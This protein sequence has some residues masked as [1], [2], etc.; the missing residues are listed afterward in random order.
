MSKETSKK[1][2]DLFVRLIRNDMTRFEEEKQVIFYGG[3]PLSNFETLEYAATIINDYIKKGLLP[4]KTTMNMVTNGTLLTDEIANRI[5]ELNITFSI[6]LD[7]ATEK[8]NS[9]RKFHNGE[10][11]FN[12]IINGIEIAKRNNCNFGLSMTL[13]EDALKE[14]DKIYDL[15]DKYN[16]NSIGFNILL[17]DKNYSVPDSYFIEASSFLVEAYKVFRQK[18]IYE[19]RMMRKVDAFVNHRLYLQDCA[20]QGGNQIIIAPNGEIGLCHGY[21]STRETFVDKVGNDS[22]DPTK[23]EVFIEWNK[24]SPVNMNQCLFCPALGFCGGGCPLNA[25]A[26]GE[27]I[28]D[29]D[30]R[31]CIHAKATQEF[32]IWDLFENI[33]RKPLINND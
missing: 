6:S 31:F 29:L 14:K 10:Y 25:K 7:G 5:K 20:A 3:E 8:A 19:D 18:G 32:L 28:W 22:F 4:E 9:C 23:N 27:S 26:N 12:K 16:I 1:A 17:T 2:I 33:R 24:R 13:S 30:K 15:L 21:L 11:G